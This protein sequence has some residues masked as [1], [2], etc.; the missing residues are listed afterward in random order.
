MTLSYSFEGGA[1]EGN[2]LVYILGSQTV[3]MLDRYALVEQLLNDA[4]LPAFANVLINVSTVLN[5]PLPGEVPYI[6]VLISKLQAR[7]ASKKIAIVNDRVGHASVSQLVSM[8]SNGEVRAYLSEKD[9]RTWIG[10]A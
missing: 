7:F 10:T 4:V 8:F 1:N 5:S 3:T 2:L 6:P 9:A